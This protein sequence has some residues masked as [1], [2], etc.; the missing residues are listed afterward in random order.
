MNLSDLAI[1]PIQKPQIERSIHCR[2][3]HT[4]IYTH[5][6]THRHLLADGRR[7][8]EQRKAENAARLTFGARDTERER[9]ARER[10]RGVRG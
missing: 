3:V 10:G 5:T 2:Y 7:T 8:I 1:C 9:R 6:H 4:G